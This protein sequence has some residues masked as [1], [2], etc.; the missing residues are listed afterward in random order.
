K[1]RANFKL[2]APAMSVCSCGEMKLPHRVCPVC[3]GYRGKQVL[4]MD[5][6]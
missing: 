5:E 1:R 4:E 6:E 2:N 3:G